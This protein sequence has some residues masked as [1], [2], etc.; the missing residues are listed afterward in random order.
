[1][2]F[3]EDTGAILDAPTDVVWR[4]LGSPDHGP[5]HARN[6]RNFR[7]QETVGPTSLISA[8]RL[9]HGHWSAFLSKSTDHAPLCVV[10]EEV[11][12]DFAG[13]KFVVVYRPENRA[14]RVDVYGD[15]RSLRFSEAEAQ[16]V[17]L[18]LLQAAYEDDE[19]AIRALRSSGRL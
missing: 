6:V 1:M 2:V 16:R 3:F 4:Y 8:E 17:F 13:T 18:E 7:V 12:G 11:E 10:N 19:T 15:V 9:L 5:A 14:T